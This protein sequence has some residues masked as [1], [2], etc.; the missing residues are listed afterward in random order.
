[1]K[2]FPALERLE[3]ELEEGNEELKCGCSKGT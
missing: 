2:N 3:E 1:M